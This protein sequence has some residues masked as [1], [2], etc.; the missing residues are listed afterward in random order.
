MNEIYYKSDGEIFCLKEF[1]LAQIA[2]LAEGGVGWSLF[3]VFSN[4]YANRGSYGSKSIKKNIPQV[5][6]LYIN[7]NLCR[8]A[9][10]VS[11]LNNMGFLA[12]NDQFFI[13]AKA[14][15]QKI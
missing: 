15:I 1:L 11:H 3:W 5:S 9:M 12:L 10:Q 6:S 4:F 13:P 8:T 2:F 14:M 7:F